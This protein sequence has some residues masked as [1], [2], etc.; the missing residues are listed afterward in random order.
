MAAVPGTRAKLF[1]W[2]LRHCNRWRTGRRHIAAQGRRRH[3]PRAAVAGGC[4]AAQAATRPCLPRWRQCRW[5]TGRE[6]GGAHAC[7]SEDRGRGTHAGGSYCRSASSEKGAQRKGLVALAKVK[8]KGA[9][10]GQGALLNQAEAGAGQVG[11]SRAQIS[12][13]AGKGGWSIARL[14]EAGERKHRRGLNAAQMGWK[15][16]QG[17]QPAGERSAGARAGLS[18]IGRGGKLSECAAC[19][20]PAPLSWTPRRRQAAAACPSRRPGCWGRRRSRPPRSGRG[21]C[22]AAC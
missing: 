16:G 19:G 13:H 15:Q 17:R 22:Q 2:I 1:E 14:M 10:V 6:G 20:R 8:A 9:A 21:S 12:A 7:H 18:R 5:F 3:S 11:F 4:A